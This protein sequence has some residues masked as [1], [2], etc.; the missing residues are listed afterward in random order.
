MF[1]TLMKQTATRKTGGRF[2]VHLLA[3]T[4][5]TASPLSAHA[6]SPEDDGAMTAAL[7]SAYVIP[8]I[9]RL[10]GQLAALSDKTTA[11]CDASSETT[12]TEFRNA[13]TDAV[14]AFAHVSFLRFGAMT[15]NNRLER[16]AFLPD[17]RGV[18]RRQVTKIRAAQEPS[19]LD[20]NALRK[21]SVA[22]QGLTALEQI[23]F[24]ADG[25]L[26][27]GDKS[28]QHDFLCGYARALTQRLVETSAEALKSE[29]AKDGQTALLLAP[30]ADN[31]LVRTPREATE[32]VFNMLVTGVSTLRDQVLERA[33]EEGTPSARATRIPFARSHN[34]LTFVSASLDGLQS[35]FGAGQFAAYVPENYAWIGPSIDFEF[36]N[37]AKALKKAPFPAAK[38]LAEPQGRKTL[39]YVEIVLKGLRETIAGEL[40]GALEL[41]GGFNSLDGD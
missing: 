31:P 26:T 10:N 25:E 23:A 14:K 35:A 40:A 32:Y 34:G 36:S 18:V 28:G 33:L 27:L 24:S 21:K 7:F 6:A 29:R 37:A 1:Q 20:P 17:A 5:L 9:D 16:L 12:K 19:V 38:A 4:L 30:G 2:A 15:H 39:E 11:L 13:F 8:S 41:K 3:F 22:L